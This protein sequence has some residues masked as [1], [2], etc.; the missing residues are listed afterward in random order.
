VP[1][2]EGEG[3]E[4]AEGQ[5]GEANEGT[6]P[7]GGVFVGE[8]L[9][10]NYHERLREARQRIKALLGQTVQKDSFTWTVI[11]EHHSDDL[12]EERFIG[13]SGI[14]LH[15]LE[16]KTKFA[17]LLLHLM[18]KDWRQSL[19]KMNDKI[20]NHNNNTNNKENKV[21][22]FHESKFIS[23]L[24]LMI[25]ASCYSDQGAFWLVVV[26][27]L[28]WCG[29]CCSHN[30]LSSLFYFIFVLRYQLMVSF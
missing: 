14:E 1:E 27:F 7:A 4:G 29:C 22:L 10:M 18:F 12:P 13:V 28:C 11:E 16:P 15:R 23:G 6:T 20:S 30:V 5:G 24:A 2:E 9:P 21:A 26:C 8:D 19:K 25:G 3:A 17:S